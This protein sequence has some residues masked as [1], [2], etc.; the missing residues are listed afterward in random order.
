MILGVV[1]IW[2]R[3]YF[4]T[5]IAGSLIAFLAIIPMDLVNGTR[6]EEL[7]TTTDIITT[8]YEDDP[9]QIDIYP[10]IFFGLLG[11]MFMI[12]GSLSWKADKD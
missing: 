1:G 9:V 11:S 2:S 8:E 10:K 5:I 3:V 7:D 12:G 6:I 4:L